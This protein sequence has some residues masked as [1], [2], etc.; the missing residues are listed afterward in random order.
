VIK[1]LVFENF[2]NRSKHVKT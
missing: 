1:L 2:I